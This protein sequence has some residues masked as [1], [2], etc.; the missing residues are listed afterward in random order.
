MANWQSGQ[1]FTNYLGVILQCKA[2]IKGTDTDNNSKVKT[3]FVGYIIVPM[4]RSRAYAAMEGPSIIRYDSS[5]TKPQFSDNGY[6]IIDNHG[7]TVYSNRTRL[8]LSGALTGMTRDIADKYYPTIE[9][10]KT[11]NKYHL[12]PKAMYFHDV[13]NYIGYIDI[14]DGHNNYK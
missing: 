14:D 4:R 7:Q 13:N 3:E 2:K 5:G 10:H 9:Q 12:H 6:G 1:G 8:H 11:D